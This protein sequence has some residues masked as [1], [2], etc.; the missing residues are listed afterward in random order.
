VAINVSSGDVTQNL[1]HRLNKFFC[2]LKFCS[3]EHY[4]SMS[5]EKKSLG[6][7]VSRRGA[8]E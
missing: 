1:N 7:G 2:S 4:F 6:V 5:Q 3:L 8:E